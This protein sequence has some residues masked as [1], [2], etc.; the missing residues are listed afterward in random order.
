MIDTARQRRIAGA[1]G[2]A[3]AVVMLVCTAWL[4]ADHAAAVGRAEA[5]AQRIAELEERAQ[6][7]AAAAP[8]LEAE[9][10]R[11]TD[12]SLARDTRG[13]RLAWVLLAAGGLFVAAGKRYVKLSGQP[14]PAL[15]E[16]VALRFPPPVSANG[17]KPPA[18]ATPAGADLDLTFVDDLVV[19]LGG[20]REMAIPVLQ[21]IQ[22]HYRYLPEEA[23]RRVC[24]ATDISPAQLAGSASFY[25]QFRRDPIGRTLVRVCHGT[26]CHVAGVERIHDELRR[27]LDIAPGGDTDP[28]RL[29]TLDPVACLGCCSLAPVMMIDDDTAGHLTPAAARQALDA[30]VPPA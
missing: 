16:L 28:R 6:T 15:A 8:V 3:A 29:F 10:Q 25:S 14:L 19:R 26:A 1:A 2:L 21:A 5:D 22:G 24:E 18:P 4:I 11:Q 20:G 7:D 12:L 30:L 27:H 9:R 13:Y 23:L 17:R